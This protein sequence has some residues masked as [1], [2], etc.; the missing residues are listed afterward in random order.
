M[1]NE[2]QYNPQT[3]RSYKTG[4]VDDNLSIHLNIKW[5]IQLCVAVSGVVYGYLQIT[6]RIIIEEEKKL[7]A[8]EEQLDWYKKELNLN[9]LSWGKKKRK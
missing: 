8:M 7:S 6:N 2:K 5:L 3:S 9:P 4:L 1:G